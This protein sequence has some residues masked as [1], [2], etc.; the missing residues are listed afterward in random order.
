[1]AASSEF[2]IRKCLP[3]DVQD[4]L[5]LWLASGATP[6][7]TDDADSVLSAVNSDST[8]FLAGEADGEIIASIIG[9]YDGWRGNIY[10]LAVH[11]DYRRRGYA[12]LLVE[13]ERKWFKMRG[14]KRVT[15]LVEK[16]H[17]WAM[18]FWKAAGYDIDLRI[19]RFALN[20]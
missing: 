9:T 2:H 19:A 16:D 14:V 7:R 1:M 5:K 15:A 13:E 4:V 11:P 10:R 6:S 3:G 18:A 20:L 12:L 17:P 8:N